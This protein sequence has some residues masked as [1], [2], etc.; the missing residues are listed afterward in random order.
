M[1]S[2]DKMH[3][4]LSEKRIQSIFFFG[5]LVL[6]SYGI[7]IDKIWICLLPILFL[8]GFILTLNYRL[9]YW[10]LILSVPLS[11]TK[12]FS[13]SLSTDF[14]TEFLS[15]ILTSIF[16]V[17]YFYYKP[18]SLKKIWNSKILWVLLLGLLW[19]GFSAIFACDKIIALKFN[20]AKFWYI[21][22]YFVFTYWML[23]DINKIRRI[24]WILYIGITF[25][26][27]CG[28]I[29]TCLGGFNF[30]HTNKYSL[31]FY[32]NHVIY[33]SIMTLFLPF[34]Y[35]ARSWYK[36]GSILKMI[37]FWT[38]PFYLIA[39][40]FSYTRACYLAIIVGIIF[41]ILIRMRIALISFIMTIILTL[42]ILFFF[43]KDYFYLRLAPDYNTTVMHENF[44]D[45]LISTFYGKDVSS[46]ERL[47]MWVS[48]FRMYQDN[49][50]TGVGPNNFPFQ[51]KPYGV[52][53]FKT[54]VSDNPLH[55]SCHNYFWLL[56]AEQ[57]VIGCFIFILLLTTVIYYLQRLYIKSK[58]T[59]MKKIC[60]M[61]SSMLGA[62]IV[63]LF[64][65][66]L[67]E[68]SKIGSIFFIYIAIL[69]KYIELNNEERTIG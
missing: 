56:L 7:Y 43:S 67:I 63:I 52:L 23:E 33:A 53:Y 47:N 50:W 15:I 41:T 39:I 44:T 48:V 35:M 37:L 64:F 25:T 65:N 46:M 34:I 17:I 49:P 1:P 12:D 68:S 45:H 19:S 21:T 55:L 66:D 58:D 36:P 10:A 14:P 38:I 11:V 57:G 24:F 60:L 54:W 59:E 69:A 62:L 32:D 29:N 27:I 5:F 18:N 6:L 40:Y 30:E 4:L 20:L 42:S 26:A 8:A 2:F 51:Y 3:F 16:W 61:I 9:L 31:P 28:F 22:S 13:N